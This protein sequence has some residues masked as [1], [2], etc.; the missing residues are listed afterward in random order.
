MTIAA[1]ET[2]AHALTGAKDRPSRELVVAGV[3][4]PLELWLV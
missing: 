1:E 4:G 3:F 2:R